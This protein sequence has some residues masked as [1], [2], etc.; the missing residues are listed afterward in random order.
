MADPVRQEIL[1]NAHTIVVKLGIL[2]GLWIGR[3]EAI[4]DGQENQQRRLKKVGHHRGE[5]VVVAEFD[6]R[7]AHS[8]V[9]IDDRKAI[10]FE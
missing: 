8:V 1:L 4:D 7:N 9:F 5:M 3:I 6:F 2:I 10:P